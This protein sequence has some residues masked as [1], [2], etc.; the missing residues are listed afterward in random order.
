MLTA[1]NCPPSGHRSQQE[2]LK[3]GKNSELGVFPWEAPHFCKLMVGPYPSEADAGEII[4]WLGLEEGWTGPGSLEMLHQPE[5][6]KRKEERNSGH[7]VR[8]LHSTKGG[9]AELG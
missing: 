4:G 5:G 9:C 8:S 6:G 3:V 2:Q 1:A 7:S